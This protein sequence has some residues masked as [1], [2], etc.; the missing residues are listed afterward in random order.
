MAMAWRSQARTPMKAKRLGRVDGVVAADVAGP[1]IVSK[2]LGARD[3]QETLPGVRADRVT[4]TGV[5]APALEA[6]GAAVLD[7]GPAGR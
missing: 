7:I 5:V 1:R 4:E 2:Q 3:V 6:I